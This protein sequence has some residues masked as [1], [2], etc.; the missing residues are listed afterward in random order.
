MK[1]PLSS[2]WRCYV[3]GAVLATL[4][5]LWG[6]NAEW[7][8]G[9]MLDNVAHDV[10]FDLRAPLTPKQVA[11]ELPRS[12]R[13]VIIRL[14]HAVPRPVLG[15]LI[16][17]LRQA[18][19]VALDLLLVDRASEIKPYESGWYTSE[20]ARW[21]IE[22]HALAGA[23]GRTRHVVTG[24]WPE[25][26]TDKQIHW[27]PPAA[28]FERS[29]RA[30]T[31]FEVVPDI[32]DG[33][34]RRLRLWEDAARF[35]PPSSQQNAPGTKFSKTP[36][37]AAPQFIPALSLQ[38][39][40]LAL[41]KTPEQLVPPEKRDLW[42]DFLGP[43]TVLERQNQNVE[44]Q[45]ALDMP[46]ESFK[47]ALVFVGE[48]SFQSKDVLTTPCGDMPG[49]YIHAQAVATLLDERGVPTELPWWGVAGMALGASLLLVVPL[50]HRT[51]TLL[52]CAL[53]AANEIIVLALCVAFLWATWRIVAPLSVPLVAVFL[54]YNGIALVE[55]E[56]TR[57]LLGRVVGHTL[58]GRL[59]DIR[60]DP[61]LGGKEEV[62]TALFCDLRG[63]SEM[64]RRFE[65]QQLISFLNAYTGNVVRVVEE[66]KGRPIDFFGD[67][68]FVLFEGEGHVRNAIAAA[69]ALSKM[70]GDDNA[71]GL[72]AGVALNTGP[73]VIGFVGHANHLKPGAVGEVVNLAARVQTLSDECH[74]TVLITRQ[75]LEAWQGEPLEES[76]PLPVCAI[77]CGSWPIKG[78]SEELEVFGLETIGTV[79]L[80][81]IS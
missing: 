22:D 60:A 30:T 65:P 45:D 70:Y 3:L 51:R 39:A 42:I 17:N 68:V 31:H 73:M 5:A 21:K 20:I 72:H 61:Q 14:P 53:V 29:A 76:N 77:S 47:D 18:K 27:T 35:A 78:Y 4:V 40:A 24:A 71:E 52:F 16:E 37:K 46:E 11:E 6:W 44:Y 8:W 12:N 23:I 55:Y 66:F 75:T 48:T 43:R 26:E 63:Y 41:G 49:M 2:R 57:N 62:A 33:L 13:I 25:L 34:T 80:Q 9:V 32:Q 64:A 67:G 56:W 74:H 15:K 7:R 28:L 19:V 69:M 79:T 59:L 50:L 54:T 81:K 58:L 10:G 1:S 38:V 36:K